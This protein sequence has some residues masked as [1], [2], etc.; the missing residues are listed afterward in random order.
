MIR[1]LLRFL[2]FLLRLLPLVILYIALY[3]DAGHL[4]LQK[5]GI[6]EKEIIVG[7]VRFH[8]AESPDNRK[9]VLLLIHAQLLEWFSYQRVMIPLSQYF[10]VYAVDCP[11]HGKTRC[12]DDFQM[13]A[14]QIGS[15]LAQFIE[16]VIGK[17]TAVCGNS[18]GGLL[19]VWLAANRPELIRAAILEDPPLFSSEYP[20]IR[21]TI[22]Y[23]TFAVSDRAVRQ[24]NEGDY[25]RFWI[26]NSPDFFKN[27]AFPGAR[28]MIR[29]LIM[30]YRMLHWQSIVELP[31]VP[32]L[33]REMIRGMDQYDPHFGQAFYDGTW[34]EHFD[35]A[36]ALR[37]IRCPVLLMQADT[38]FLPDGTLNGAMSEENAQFACSRLQDVRYVK[39]NTRHVVHL[40][41]PDE[42]LKHVM[43]FLREH[44]RNDN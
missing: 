16:K 4:K 30:L 28:T 22:A 27:N 17:P 14:D 8:Y 43:P 13:N 21:H 26:R 6:M 41:E 44:N 40:E 39:V 9:P 35:H 29:V 2:L 36:E 12:P 32:V 20:A 25:I 11:G 38:S 15:S 33:F 31:F 24:D 37:Q 3:R 1:I 42:Y 5:A 10:H 18:S 7:D 19:A 23:R 34:N